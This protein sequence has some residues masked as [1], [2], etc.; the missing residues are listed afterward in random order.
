MS[1]PDTSLQ[2]RTWIDRALHSPVWISATQAAEA[3]I[4]ACPNTPI[5]SSDE[6]TARRAAWEALAQAIGETETAVQPL[7]SRIQALRTE[8][9][10]RVSA[11]I[12]P[13]K[14]RVDVVRRLLGAWDAQER[15]RLEAYEAEQRKRS[16]ERAYRTLVQ[17]Q[18]G[19]QSRRGQAEL[20]DTPDAP[21][22]PFT[23][24][25]AEEVAPPAGAT[26]K[27]RKKW[28]VEILDADKLRAALIALPAGAKL[29][30]AL[31]VH[32][33]TLRQLLAN[34]LG[35]EKADSAFPAGCVSVRCEDR[36]VRSRKG[37]T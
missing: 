1:K 4:T 7:R 32:E 35:W 24:K 3:A 22:D 13:A 14:A 28:L 34:E 19:D 33:P 25:P 9:A 20:P 18:D 29:Q 8:L 2:V 36:A 16:S 5:E 21:V 26:G 31:R 10:A 12:D 23:P 15:V 30:T 6:A 37:I 27:T 11:V 17:A